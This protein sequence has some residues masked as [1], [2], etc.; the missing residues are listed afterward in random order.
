MPIG[1]NRR[2][3]IY[4]RDSRKVNSCSYNMD[5]ET[6]LASIRQGPSMAMAAI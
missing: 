1:C 6:I 3:K 5:Q 4:I 2:E